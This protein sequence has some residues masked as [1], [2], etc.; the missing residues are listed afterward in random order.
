MNYPW[1]TTKDCKKFCLLLF[2]KFRRRWSSNRK[3]WKE[4]SKFTFEFIIQLFSDLNKYLNVYVV[5]YKMHKQNCNNHTIRKQFAPICHCF[6][7]LFSNSLC[8]FLSVS[9]PMRV[10]INVGLTVIKQRQA[11]TRFPASA[12]QGFIFLFHP[13]SHSARF[14]L[15]HFAP[16]TRL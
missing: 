9:F 3:T 15:P 8:M 11:R 14:A 10:I 5:N 16:V 6:H 1:S 2:K 13:L 4:I 12:M 7:C